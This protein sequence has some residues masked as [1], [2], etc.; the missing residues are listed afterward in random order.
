MTMTEPR[1]R[2][3]RVRRDQDARLAGIAVVAA[4]VYDA[5]DW[6][7]WN[8]NDAYDDRDFHVPG[9]DE[10]CTV[11]ADLADRARA[12][13]ADGAAEADRRVGRLRFLASADDDGVVT[14]HLSI[15]STFT[16]DTSTF[17]ADP[18]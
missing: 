7:R 6:A 11:L 9:A 4:R 15:G 17:P 14:F 8:G 1:R 18:R 3:A 16:G 5:C 2:G 13:A 12:A 10:L